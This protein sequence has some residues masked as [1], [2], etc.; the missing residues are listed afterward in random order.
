MVL[1][2]GAATGRIGCK[3]GSIELTQLVNYQR[4]RNKDPT[5]FMTC[6]FNENMFLAN[7]VFELISLSGKKSIID[8]NLRSKDKNNRNIFHFMCG[9][10]FSLK[11]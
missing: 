6:F 1:S 3:L 8:F 2:S 4:K 9:K 10:Y 7:F 11:L 5:F